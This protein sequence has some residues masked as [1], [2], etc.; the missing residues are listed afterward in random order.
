MTVTRN[1]RDDMIR[2]AGKSVYKGIAMGPIVVMKKN[3]T[4]CIDTGCI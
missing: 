4:I 2:L 3:D 1:G